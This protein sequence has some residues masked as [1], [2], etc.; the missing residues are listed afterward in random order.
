MSDLRFAD[1]LTFIVAGVTGL[2]VAA[3]AAL[4]PALRIV[5]LNP[6]RALRAM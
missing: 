2:W 1:P 6:I 5:R 3:F 4:V